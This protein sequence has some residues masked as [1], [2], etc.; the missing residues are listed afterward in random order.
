MLMTVDRY[1]GRQQQYR[2]LRLVFRF[3]NRS[4][5]Y[6]V[7]VSSVPSKVIICIDLVVLGGGRRSKRELASLLLLSF[8][9]P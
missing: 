3:Q 6:S 5:P 1:R 9:L 7:L 4:D 8:L 2:D